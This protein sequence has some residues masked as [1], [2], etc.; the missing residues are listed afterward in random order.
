MLN[1]LV[2][3]IVEFVIKCVADV[4]CDVVFVVNCSVVVD[5]VSLD[6]T[7]VIW[8]CVSRLILALVVSID[9]DDDELINDVS[10]LLLVVASA[11]EVD[12]SVC[13]S[14]LS[15]AIDDDESWIVGVV[16]SFKS[17]DWRVRL[18]VND[19]GDD[20]DDDDELFSRYFNSVDRF[21]LVSI[22]LFVV[23][24]HSLSWN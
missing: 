18:S 12:I 19:W 1:E 23:S 17:V 16:S 4:I 22:K 3:S 20:D 14:C 10:E 15:E 6:E 21:E 5:T 8:C 7:V 2:D 9:D 11:F 13:D 24:S